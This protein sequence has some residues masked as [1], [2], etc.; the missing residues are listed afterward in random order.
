MIVG[1][2]ET[3][4]LYK[5]RKSRKLL[6]RA[7]GSLLPPSQNASCRESEVDIIDPIV[8][9]IIKLYSQIHTYQFRAILTLSNKIPSYVV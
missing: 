9:Y 2:N 4:C 8:L 1:V 6:G 3:N 7:R 5:E